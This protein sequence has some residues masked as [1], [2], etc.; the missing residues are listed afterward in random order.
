VPIPAVQLVAKKTYWF[1]I[2]G[3]KGQIKFRNRIGAGNVPLETSA[4]N[5]LTTL[6][7]QWVTGS[8]FA[9]DGP[10]SVYGEGYLAP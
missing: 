5:V 3:S 2:L 8:V 7:A 1:A 6:P 4:S 9:N 10:M